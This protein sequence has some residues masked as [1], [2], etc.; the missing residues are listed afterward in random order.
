MIGEQIANYKLIA[1]L[2]EGGMGTVY[3]GSH[4]QLGRK[5]AIKAL[6]PNLVNNP[7]IRE[8]FKNEAATLANI[9]HQNIVGLYDYLETTKG[10]FLIM[11][12]V[13]GKPLDEF[14][15]QVSGPVAE[16]IAIHLMCQILDGF[17]YAHKQGIVHRDIKPSNLLIT[18]EGE[19]KILDF[20]IAKILDNSRKSLTQDG[21]RMGTVLYMSPEQVRGVAI[22][23]RSDIYSLGVTLFQ[24]VTGKCPYDEN[25]ATEYAVYQEIVNVP[26][27]RA[28]TFYPTISAK[29]QQ[30]IDIATAK[31][32]ND[33][34]Q[35][36]AEFK[37]ALL[38]QS[39]P[40]NQTNPT[41]IQ[42]NIGGRQTPKPERL[43]Q[44]APTG[45]TIHYQNEENYTENNHEK[46]TNY[47]LLWGR[48]NYWF[49]ILLLLSLVGATAYVLLF[50]PFQLP[51][52]EKI[53]FF[54]P[55]K[56]QNREAAIKEKLKAFFNAIESH[57]FNNIKDFYADSIEEYFDFKNV[58]LKPI[59]DIKSAAEAY[60]KTYAIAEKHEID[61]TTFKYEIDENHN[62]IAE[63]T[64]TYRF[65][66]KARKWNSINKVRNKIKFNKD[67]QIFSI[68]K[69]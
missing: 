46:T 58:D 52:L 8:R 51:I 61:W 62:H 47:K 65:E 3:V 15:A 24:M 36:C 26:L 44:T 43:S 5:A 28:N 4:I 2:G 10:L 37:A 56:P 66:N 19:A 17:D 67:L 18:P 31:N 20:G 63:I 32:P 50:N 49:S 33:R 45:N 1:K 12:Y 16:D 25:N 54:A 6:H 9:K 30:I 13:Q 14:I 34:F 21:S 27:P 69:S 11:E 29:M 35:T 38:G 7:Q 42:N 55:E 48:V 53:A 64:F 40:I 39:N 59:P 22:D 41:F 60:W 57:D 23:T 68:A